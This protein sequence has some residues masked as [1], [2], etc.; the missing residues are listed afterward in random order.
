[1]VKI[2]FLYSFAYFRFRLVLHPIRQTSFVDCRDMSNRIQFQTFC[3]KYIENIIK[4][5]FYDTCM[6][7][8]HYFPT[9]ISIKMLA[10][11]LK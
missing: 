9:N 11:T 1:M 6:D 2:G 10:E 8:I 4:N 7:H 5:L 3:M